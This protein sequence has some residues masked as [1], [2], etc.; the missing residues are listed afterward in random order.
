MTENQC[1]EAS[2][3]IGGENVKWSKFEYSPLT[4]KICRSITK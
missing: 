3:L 4:A 2:S 1:K